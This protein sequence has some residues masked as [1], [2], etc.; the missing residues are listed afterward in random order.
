MTES[1][2]ETRPPRGALIVIAVGLF[3]TL[4]AAVLANEN[5]AGEAA[6]LEWVQTKKLP[7]SETASIP[8]GGGEMQLTHA[9]LRATG[10]NVS[11]Y[12]LFS[13]AAT[14]RIDA[15]SPVGSARIQCA[16]KAGAQTE[17]GQTP[18]SRA[19]YPRSSDQLTEQ[20]VPESVQV[21]FSSHGTNLAELALEGLPG[22]FATETGIKLEWPTYRIGVERWRWFLPPGPPKAELVLP[23]ATV[24]K[25]TRIPSVEIACTVSTSAGE[26]SVRTGGAFERLSEPIAE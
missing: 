5:L 19:S 18:G 4:A 23:F 9:G 7:D 21:E 24:W 3:A 20:P 12:S 6:G 16:M 15:G 25:A 8:G 1:G 17:V 2:N 26:A 11:N 14:L 13:S 22:R 10:V